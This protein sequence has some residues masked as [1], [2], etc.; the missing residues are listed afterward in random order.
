MKD[1]RNIVIALFA[2]CTVFSFNGAQAEEVSVAVASNALQALNEIKKRFEKNTG[3]KV[4]VSSGSTGKLYTQIVNGA[5]YD[6]FL[7]AN[8]SEPLRLEQANA[9]VSGSRFTY[10]VGRLVLWSNSTP[11]QPVTNGSAAPISQLVD[12]SSLKRITLANPKTA[13]YG[14][15]AQQYLQSMKLWDALQNK[16]VRAENVTQAFQFIQSQNVQLGFVALS[17]IKAYPGHINEKDY[18]LVPQQLYTPIEQQGVLLQRA[19]DNN[20]AKQFMKYLASPE[21]KKLLRERYGY[22][23]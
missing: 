21:V 6:I 23:A 2:I 15:A 5:P 10:A 4:S 12:S 22:D 7:A 8:S 1:F 3:I 16:L 19:S 17:Q 11:I 18:W 20:A 14:L 9:T 13:P